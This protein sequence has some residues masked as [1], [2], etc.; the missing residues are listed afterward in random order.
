MY[1]NQF[2]TENGKYRKKKI[3]KKNQKSKF[4]KS[5]KSQGRFV[6]SSPWQKRW[7]KKYFFPELELN[8]K[9]KL[10]INQLENEKK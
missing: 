10:V 5:Y 1:S 6:F 8:Q 9:L 2:K 4:Y 3:I 7:A